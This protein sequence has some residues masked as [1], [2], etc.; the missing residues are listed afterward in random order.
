MGKK[1]FI[2]YTQNDERWATW[3]AEV[4]EKYGQTALV[5]AWDIHAGDNFI[6]K[7]HEFLRE[8]DVCVPILSYSYFASAYCE[9]EWTNAFGMA[10]KDK[11]KQIIPV[12]VSDVKPEGLL[13]GC[14]YID[15]FE[16]QDET[17]ASDILLEGMGI[18]GKKRKATGYPGGSATTPG[19]RFPG[20]LPQ[21]NLPERNEYFTGRGE[22]LRDIQTKFPQNNTICLKQTIIGLGG[23]GKT[24]TALEYAYRYAS[25]YHDAI[26][27]VN[28]DSDIVAFSDV[29]D[30]A[31]T[32]GIIPEGIDE[33]R[34]L[35]HKQLGER[36]RP[37]FA[38]HHS[39]LFIFDNVETK[40]VTK[41]YTK[42]MQTGHILITTRDREFKQGKSLDI[43]LFTPKEA[44]DFMHTRLFECMDLI[45]ERTALDKLIERLDYFPLALEQSAAY[46][47]R[48]Q[49]SCQK[50]LSLLENQGLE[51]LLKRLGKPTNYHSAV[52]ETI[53]LTLDR[54]SKGA[55]QLLFI[56]SYMSPDRIPIAFFE[57]Q[58]GKFP[59]PL[60]EDLAD[61]Y[62]AIEIVTELIN[63][64][65]VKRDGDSFLNIHRLVQEIVRGSTKDDDTD[66]LGIC[67]DSMI[68]AMP[69]VWDY[70]HQEPRYWFEQIAAHAASI[71]SCKRAV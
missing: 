46:I 13:Y 23:V 50:Y 8:C 35:S 31:E 18:I 24:Q 34:K 27:W 1:Y 57:R 42:A 12:K 6:S 5:Q 10:V 26:W 36:L 33:A 66:W 28:A 61:P 67:L 38:G 63:Y 58:C 3:I 22:V 44:A 16:I 15:L 69:D 43:D 45:E 19:T 56:C 51:S 39:W 70:S 47:D 2:S 64:S 68:A 37:W 29:L 48:T 40:E 53:T 30:F 52:P 14:V 20:A 25:E 65:I 54:L 59:Q 21:N 17:N 11:D 4:L 49:V 9:T 55:K 7:M 60:C 41:P 32:F 71:V 62:K